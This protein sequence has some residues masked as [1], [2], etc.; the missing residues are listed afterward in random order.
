[1]HGTASSGLVSAVSF[2]M[3]RPL[4]G[5]QWCGTTL[6]VACLGQ[7]KLQ[8]NL[9]CPKIQKTNRKVKHTFPLGFCSFRL[10]FHSLWMAL[11]PSASNPTPE[12]VY[13]SRTTCTQKM[14]N[15]HIFHD[16]K[17]E[18]Y[19]KKIQPF[20]SGQEFL[21]LLLH[22]IAGDLGPPLVPKVLLYQASLLRFLALYLCF[23]MLYPH[24]SIQIYHQVR[25]YFN[26]W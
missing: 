10:H 17:C 7:K 23:L 2:V 24:H 18:T 4:F 3:T 13:K 22:G 15:T 5:C 16:D 9:D 14:L 6:A 12:F 21:A 20:W 26:Y 8:H 11:D 25:C 19:I 1:M